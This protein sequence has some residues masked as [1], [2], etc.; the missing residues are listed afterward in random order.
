[1]ARYL[2]PWSPDP[3]GKPEYFETTVRPTN[4]RGFQIFHRMPK[5]FELVKD[6][7]CLTQRAGGGALK[8]LVDALLGDKSDHPEWLVDSA[9]S[10]MLAHCSPRRRAA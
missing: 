8:S 5:S 3:I 6:G 4:Y 9:R 1:M 2:S 7:V 10:V